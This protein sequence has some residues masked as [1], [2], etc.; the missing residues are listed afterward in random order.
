[1]AKR[2][3]KIGLMTYT[4]ADGVA[5]TVGFQGDEVDVHADDVKRF[6]ELNVQPGGDEP[7]QEPRA[8]VDLLSSPGAEVSGDN[9]GL[10]TSVS[11]K[12]VADSTAGDDTGDKPARSRKK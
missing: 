6:D 1:M 5:G 2:T 10:N 11:D 3:V 12:D 8:S 4:N 7:Y 9:S